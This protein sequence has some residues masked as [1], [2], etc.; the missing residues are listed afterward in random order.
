MPKLE[1]RRQVGCLEIALLPSA[2]YRVKYRAKQSSLGFALESQAGIHAIATDVRS[3][4]RVR[5]NS[6]AWL[7]A[8]C[9]VFSASDAG[10]EYLSVS[11]FNI[12]GGNNWQSDIFASVAARPA[13]QLWAAMLL[14]EDDL[15]LEHLTSS[16]FTHFVRAQGQAPDREAK[17][18]TEK[19][20]RRIDDIINADLANS[21]LVTDLANALGLSTGYFSRAF[22]AATGRSPQRHIIDQRLRRARSLVLS[23]NLPLTEVAMRCGFSSHSHMS[24]TFRRLMEVAPSE[25]RSANVGRLHS[26]PDPDCRG[27]RPA[28]VGGQGK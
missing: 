13:R 28:S 20:L 2:P 4:F 27:P 3:T 10:G 15:V 17:W 26:F 9:D 25:L 7:P 11:G 5:A 19:R 18:M 14:G 1:V 16:L 6:F 22:R 21:I 12:V 24:T 8:G 23:T